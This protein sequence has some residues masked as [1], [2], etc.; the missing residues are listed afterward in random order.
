MTG[1]VVIRPV[2]PAEATTISCLAQRSKAVWGYSADF[3]AACVDE[4]TYD[5][6]MLEGMP[7]AFFAAE[8]DGDIVGF[9]GLEWQHDDSCEL[10]AL[11]VQP[12]DI[13]A[14]IGMQL[15]EHAQ[16]QARLGKAAVM[17]IQG[18]PNAEA[19]Y[20]RAGARRTGTR[21]SGS[22]PGRQLPLFE[23]TL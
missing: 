12:E 18:D 17:R 8:R 10:V 11:F 23:I 2:L 21:E 7:F 9:Y 13:G 5:E 19:F 16:E 20:R 4:L 15:V 6:P 1:R 22:I 14:G 3:M